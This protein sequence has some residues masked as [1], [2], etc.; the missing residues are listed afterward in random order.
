MNLDKNTDLQPTQTDE[1][2]FFRV[3]IETRETILT[4]AKWMKFIYVLLIIYICIIAIAAI[5]FLFADVRINKA[6]NAVNG[7]WYLIIDALLLIPVRKMRLRIEAMK[8]GVNG[9]N[10][11]LKEAIR[12]NNYIWR[13]WGIFTI[14]SIAIVL[15]GGIIIITTA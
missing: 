6:P 8:K 12:L 7:I 14:V 13:F 2:Q 9:D 15:L 3:D 5:G 11:A 1:E 10:D 4:T